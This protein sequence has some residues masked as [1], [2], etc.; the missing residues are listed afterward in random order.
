MIAVNK[1]DGTKRK[2]NG[3]S[4]DYFDEGNGMV[5]IFLSNGTQLC[6]A[7]TLAEVEAAVSANDGELTEYVAG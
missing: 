7:N 6:V 4:V 5:A 3:T 1:Q 2:V